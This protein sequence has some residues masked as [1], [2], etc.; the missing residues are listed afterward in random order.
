MKT[1]ITIAILFIGIRT[2]AQDSEFKLNENYPIKSSG[3]VEMWSSDAEVTIKGTDRKDVSVNIYRKVTVKGVR[4]GERDFKVEVFEENGNLIIR[5]RSK[6]SVSMVGYSR[7]VYTIDIEAPRNVSLDLEGDDDD[8]LI[9]NIGGSIVLDIDDG[10]ADLRNCDGSDFDFDF[11]DGDIRMDGG[12]GKIRIRSDDG[13]VNI[14]NASFSEVEASM[15]DGDIEIETSLADNGTYFFRSNDGG[16]Y[17]DVPRGGGEFLIY[18]DDSRVSFS[19][20][21]EVDRDDEN[22]TRLRSR[23][24]NAKVKVRVDDGRVQINAR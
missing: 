9:E 4:F 10:D 24:G 1:L 2:V 8:Y 7:E 17:L 16:V 18:H 23:R 22:E 13:D 20:D 6:G 19:G 14:R 21:F 15:D 12:K 3:T 5:E 11:D